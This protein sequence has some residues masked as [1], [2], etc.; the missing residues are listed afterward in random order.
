M[1]RWLPQSLFSRMVLIL[2]G[3]LVLAQLASF[4]IHW[5]ERGEFILR[6]GGVRQAQRIADIVRFLDPLV[7]RER[8]QILG[9]IDSPQL[10]VSLSRPP[11]TPMA[12]D[13]DK[14]ERAARFASALRHR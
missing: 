8:A 7:P 3:G 9:V 4:A 10:Q 5:H 12:M 14:A 6:T 11:L 1:T 2:L 13:P